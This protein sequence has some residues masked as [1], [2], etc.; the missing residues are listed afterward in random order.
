[1]LDIAAITKNSTM[2]IETISKNFPKEGINIEVTITV[3]ELK[4]AKIKNPIP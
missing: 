4:T 2:P 1:M 3:N